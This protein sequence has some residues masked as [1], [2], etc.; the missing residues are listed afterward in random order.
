MSAVK[1]GIEAGHLRQVGL[2]RRDRADAGETVR[3]MQW[4]ERTERLE[5]A[6]H[7]GS[8]AHRRREFGAAMHDAVAD[9]EQRRP[10]AE[11]LAQPAADHAK[12]RVV[13]GL[14]I[15]WKPAVDQHFALGV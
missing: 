11:M 14:R 6:E 9:P 7:R 8:D 4:R 15:V 5:L 10:V 13:T 1:R 12:E 3:L 2:G